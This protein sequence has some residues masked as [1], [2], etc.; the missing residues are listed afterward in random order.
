M[1]ELALVKNKFNKVIGFVE[2][3]KGIYTLCLMGELHKDTDFEKICK[4]LISLN[5]HI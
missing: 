1:Y 2:Y 4:K 3:D 5:L